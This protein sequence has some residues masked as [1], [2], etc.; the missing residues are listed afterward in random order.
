MVIQWNGHTVPQKVTE[1][2][3]KVRLKYKSHYEYNFKAD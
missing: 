1:V 3:Q 2:T